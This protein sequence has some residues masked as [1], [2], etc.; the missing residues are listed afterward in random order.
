[1]REAMS[2]FRY[3]IQGIGHT[4]GSEA[5]RGALKKVAELAVESEAE[6]AAKKKADA[7][8]EKEA[9]KAA[10]KDA[11]EAAAKKKRDAKEIERELAELKKRVA[12]ASK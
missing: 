3:I 10:A 9:T 1:M 2:L 4:L 11:K 7:L 12:K 8:A 6:E 5:T